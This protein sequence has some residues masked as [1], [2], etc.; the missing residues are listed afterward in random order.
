VDVTRGGN[1]VSFPLVGGGLFTLPGYRAKR[2]YDLVTGLG[3]LDAARLV[4]ELAL[5]SHAN[6]SHASP[7]DTRRK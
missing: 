5:V 4:P 2:G 1:T 6:K 7:A 3:T